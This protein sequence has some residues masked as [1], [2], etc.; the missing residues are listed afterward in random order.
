MNAR[1][2]R[3]V[4]AVG[5]LAEARLGERAMLARLADATRE[6]VSVDDWLPAEQARSHPTYYQQHLLYLDPRERFSVVSFVWGPGQKTPVHDHTVWG[7]VGVLRGGEY[8]QCYR[9]AVD[10][11]VPVGPRALLRQGQVEVISPAVGD[12]HQVSNAYDD[13]VSVSIHCY[14]GNIGAVRRHV[15]DIGTGERKSFVSGYA[16]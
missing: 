9:R 6:L 1:L 3:Y 13:Q 12:I 2:R 4:D 14:G 5:S 11:L 16:A 8:A 15:Y 10:R 7:V